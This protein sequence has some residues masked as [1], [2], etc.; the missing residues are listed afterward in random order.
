MANFV[1]H[2]FGSG[3]LV[4]RSSGANPTPQ[5]FG[6]VQEAS[7]DL[8][9]DLK[10]LMGQYEGAVDIG[11]SGTKIT[12]KIKFAQFKGGIMQD[13]FWGSATG[14]T[15]GMVKTNPFTSQTIP[16]TPFVVTITPPGGGVFV[17]DLGVQYQSTGVRLKRVASAPAAGEYA[18]NEST[19]AYTFAAADTLGLVYISYDYS[20]T[21]GYTL[22][23]DNKISGNAP[24]WELR[25]DQS[26][27]SLGLHIWLYNC[28]GGKMSFPFT[29]EDFEKTDFEFEAFANTALKF[30]KYYF[31]TP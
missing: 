2:H 5:I 31:D 20:V 28:V 23:L 24:I 25:L 3:F 19:G 10:R 13:L 27:N 15:T 29:N 22:E 26:R 1:Q 11:R 14:M 21:T 9:S 6:T 12:G 16:A 8:S 7:V 17:A 18:V 30:G 4:G